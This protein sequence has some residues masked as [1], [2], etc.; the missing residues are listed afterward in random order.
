LIRKLVKKN[1]KKGEQKQRNKTRIHSPS[2]LLLHKAKR[3]PHR[4]DHSGKNITA[5]LRQ[6]QRGGTGILEELKP[7][8]DR[9]GA[10]GTRAPEELE[11]DDRLLQENKT[12]VRTKRRVQQQ[13]N[14]KRTHRRVT[15]AASSSSSSSLSTKATIA[16]AEKRTKVLG[17]R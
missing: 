13:G 4:G 1:K 9:S 8:C 2:Y 5:T 15:R 3:R 10:A 12:K 11:S 14:K 6:E 17:Q 7:P 16:P